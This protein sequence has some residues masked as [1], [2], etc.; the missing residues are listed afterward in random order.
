MDYTGKI[1]AVGCDHGG[2]LL[3]L[4]VLKHLSERGIKYRDFGCD[5]LESVNYPTY[6]HEV[7][8]AV[9]SGECV[10]G[11]LLCGTGIGMS[12]AANKHRG[13]RAAVCSDEYS[14]KM[15]R[16]HNDANVLCLGARVIDYE[17]VERLADIFLNTEYIGGDHDTR[18]KMLGEIENCSF[19]DDE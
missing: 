4:E 11:I 9:Q 3:K 13:I 10:C 14:T 7:C 16:E 6:A 1:I 18:V 2:Y 17:T 8:R 5:S 19:K 12:M 15:T